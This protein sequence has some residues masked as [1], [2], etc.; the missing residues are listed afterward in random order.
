MKIH[1]L[2]FGALVF[3]CMG[4]IIVLGIHQHA[5]QWRARQEANRQLVTNHIAVAATMEA[6]TAQ[7]EAI[8]KSERSEVDRQYA[9]SPQ[10][11][12]AAGVAAR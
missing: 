5:S 3:G 12:E 8:A 6:L 11:I 1:P 4:L 9:M 7:Q 10:G 2:S